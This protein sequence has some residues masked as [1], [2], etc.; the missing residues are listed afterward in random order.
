MG[1][2]QDLE[3]VCGFEVKWMTF[4]RPSLYPSKLYVNACC[5]KLSLSIEVVATAGP[6]HSNTKEV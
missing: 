2:G 4:D 5:V 1:G 6:F 3:F